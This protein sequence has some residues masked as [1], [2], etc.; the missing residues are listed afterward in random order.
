MD[1]FENMHRNEEE[2]THEQHD[3]HADNNEGTPVNDGTGDIPS[4]P[5]EEKREY[6]PIPPVFG[7]SPYIGNPGASPSNVWQPPQQNRAPVP[8]Q[9]G[10]WQPPHNNNI[11]HIANNGNNPQQGIYRWD[12]SDY[13]KYEQMNRVDS[14]RKK[15]RTGMVIITSLCVVLGICIVGMAGFGIYSA[16]NGNLPILGTD[17]SQAS[18]EQA[19]SQEGL[20]NIEDKPQDN[21][22]YISGTSGRISPEEV[23]QRVGPSVVSINGYSQN[24]YGVSVGSGIVFSSDGY[25]V[26]NAHVVEGCDTIQVTF[27]DDRTFDAVIIGVDTRT[28]LGVIKIEATGLTAAAFGNSDSLKLGE[29]VVAIGNG[30]GVRGSV[31]TGVVSALNR[32]IMTSATQSSMEYI[33]TDAAINPGNS[34]G[35]LVN[36]FGQVVGINTAKKVKTGYEGIGFAIPTKTAEPIINQ[37]ISNGKVTGRPIIGLTEYE[38]IDEILSRLNGI[39][40]GIYV[41]GM[42]PDSDMMAKGILI[43]D[44][45]THFNGV[46]VNTLEELRSEIAKCKA[47]DTAKMTIYRRDRTT[48]SSETLEFEIVLLEE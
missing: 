41:G 2:N 4:A 3:N 18:D 27:M 7:Q 22:G 38:I 46:K 44:I 45:V 8:Q 48:G 47:G 39:P 10:V 31:T 40:T 36:S 9:Q 16:I 33:Q 5:P 42:S 11:G 37:L 28:D 29:A 19:S 32:S 15:N 17:S 13:E 34:G 25:I 23:V 1:D 14:R 30:D 43:G 24:A 26:T 6:P 21:S 20:F 12:L 35:A